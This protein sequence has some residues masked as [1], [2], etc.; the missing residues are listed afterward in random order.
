MRD[1]SLDG[2]RCSFRFV[3]VYAVT[4]NVLNV[5][6]EE[7]DVRIGGEGKEYVGRHT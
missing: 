6:F 1:N 2:L 4:L 7:T 5:T 3:A